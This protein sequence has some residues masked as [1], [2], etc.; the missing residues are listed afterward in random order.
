[1]ARGEVVISR[2]SK[3]IIGALLFI[4]CASAHPSQES[5]AIDAATKS[6]VRLGKSID[7]WK[8]ATR[9]MNDVWLRVCLQVAEP[10]KEHT[11]DWAHDTIASGIK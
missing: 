8:N 7:G 3:S 4:L 5:D 11:C 9:K 1:M 10:G 2:M 6:I